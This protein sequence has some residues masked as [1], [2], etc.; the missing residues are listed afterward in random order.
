MQ[1]VIARKWISDVHNSLVMKAVHGKHWLRN[2]HDTDNAGILC[3]I[4]IGYF[5]QAKGDMK[6]SILMIAQ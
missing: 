4:L 2:V 6:R 3:L 5:V 1:A